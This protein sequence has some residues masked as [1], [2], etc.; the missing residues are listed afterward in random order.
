MKEWLEK[1][2]CIL[3]KGG[4]HKFFNR[5]KLRM[6]CE[7]CCWHSEGIDLYDANHETN[8]SIRPKR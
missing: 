3:F 6:E 1:L 2:R 7:F 8:T 4:H 5:R